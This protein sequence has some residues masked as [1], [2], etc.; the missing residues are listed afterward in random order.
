MSEAVSIRL[1]SLE[2]PTYV[3]GPDS[4]YP[5]YGWARWRGAYPYSTKLDLSAESSPRKHRAVVLENR[6]VKV[7]VLPD[8][9]GR[10]FRLYDKVAGTEA[11]MVPPSIK[12]QNVANRG[13][14]IA[15]GIEFN[16]GHRGHTVHTVSPVSWAMRQEGDGGASVWV[17]SVSRFTEARWALRIGLKP[18][19]AV[20]DLEIHTLAPVD[21][22][23][24]MYWW[25]N[26]GVDV[27]KESRFFY[28]GVYA[29]A[30]H[31]RHSW[32]VTDGVDYT[33]YRNRVIG[34][35]MFVVGPQRDY[36]AF[37]DYGR[38][39]G[40][41]Q[42]ADRY[43]APGQKYFTWGTDMR[44]RYWDA[45]FSDKGQ[46]YCEIQRGRHPTQG[47]TEPLAAMTH[48]SWSESWM[49]IHQT[50]GFSAVENDLV[51]S[52]VPEGPAT[53]V[54][55]LLSAVPRKNLNLQAACGEEPLG[56]WQI[57]E[58]AF[59]KLFCQRLALPK[60]KSCDRV[61]VLD[62]AGNVLL[63]WQEFQFADE[64]WF[65]QGH[66][67]EFDAGKASPEELFLEA[68]RARFGSWPRGRQNWEG[69][70]E[71]ILRRDSG[72]TGA[73]RAVAEQCLHAG[74]YLQA[75]GHVRKAL[76]RKE[77]DA[78]LLLLL[79]WLQ[80]YQNRPDEAA[81][82][83]AK[84]AR[85]EGSRRNALFA[86]GCAHVLAQRWS[87]AAAAA[88]R[89]LAERPLDR[90]ARVLKVTILRHTG[91]KQEAV[92]L[93]KPLLAEDPLWVRLHA[94]ALLLKVPVD[95]AEG[96]RMLADDSVTAA[97]PYLELGLWADAAAILQRDES[98]E[99][100]SPAVRLAHLAYAQMKLG[101]EA[102]AAATVKQIRSAPMEFANPWTTM[103]IT[104][105]SALLERHD[106]PALHCMLGNVLAGR[107][108]IDEAGAAWKRA[109]AGGLEHTVC[110]RNLA[111]LAAHQGD[112][113]A[114]LA[115]YRKAWELADGSLPLFSELD[116]YLA[117]RGLHEERLALYEKLPAKSRGRSMVAMRRV[118]QL[119]DL[120]RYDEALEELHGRTFL[121][122]EYEK[123][124]R[125][126]YNEA[127]VGR[128][129]P[130][131]E[132]GR[133]EKAAELLAKG[134]E[135]PRNINIGRN[136]LHPEEGIIR[137]FLGLV[138][139]AAGNDDEAKSHWLEA[140]TEMHY[141]GTHN[142]GYEMLAWLALGRTQRVRTMSHELEQI[143]RGEKQ[144]HAWHR[145][146]AGPGTEKLLHGMAQLAKGRVDEAGSMWAEGLK[147]NPDGRWLRLHLN[148]PPGILERM[149]RKL[150][151][152]EAK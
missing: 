131:I 16:F 69:L 71:E 58:A 54:I 42:T 14:W 33:W 92:E 139:E 149:S 125:Q 121:S 57:E 56:S 134:L 95:L 113:D 146:F 127:L 84:A 102:G 128:A 119:L 43:L 68:E 29:N 18:D 140:A 111:S 79:G 74:E 23:G 59:D 3:L 6:Y 5:T 47:T 136:S 109:V 112:H 145:W 44:G 39:H 147:E 1:E 4:P 52:V 83:F 78:E 15:G 77:F 37:Y 142:H 133:L 108:R 96:E 137:Y 90:W 70:Y 144:V 24:M 98:N 73:L 107:G 72:H 114:A 67:E 76:E 104:V 34:S 66:H 116:R 97:T 20:M 25:T 55:R 124:I 87:A 126:H 62:A 80:V 22:P 101:D 8:M 13:A 120:S 123:D 138:A 60:G 51:L 118:L 141:E 143:A 93:L 81:D 30:M 132:A 99:P 110:R 152:A 41:A 9:G 17:G 105:L 89:L 82:S 64:D 86:L 85:N 28:Y 26:A 151:G 94:E 38:K 21:L 10:V 117:A 7:V 100:F 50:D 27:T 12:F 122:G 19:R 49:P 75:E 135:Y 150:T 130:E 106:E 45:L 148:M 11:L 103:S 61:K 40:V 46:T 48:E 63:D 88:D 36:L 91:R 129:L 32:P 31:S 35:D 115:D 65:K 2:L 53:A